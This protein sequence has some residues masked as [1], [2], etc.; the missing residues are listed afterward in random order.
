[1]V[2]SKSLVQ[3][4]IGEEVMK[5]SYDIA[6]PFR[7]SCSMDAM[8]IDEAFVRKIPDAIVFRSLIRAYVKR[9]EYVI[10]SNLDQSWQQLFKLFCISHRFAP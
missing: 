7:S 8:P 1:M 6:T 2:G 5:A 10:L 4:S 3:I 9:Y